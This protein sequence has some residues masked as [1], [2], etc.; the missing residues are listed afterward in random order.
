MSSKTIGLS[1]DLHRYLLSVTWEETDLLRRLRE[2]TEAMPMGRM[3]ISAEQGQFMRLLIELLQAKKTLE[4]G[5]FT[6]YSSLVVAQ[7]M[8]PEGRVVA[9]DVSEEWTSIGRRYWEEA[10]VA[11]KIDLRLGPA[12]ET[13]QK[14]VDSGEAGT[15]DFAFI[16]A[17]KSN[18][19]RYYEMALQLVRPRGL[20]GFDN[21]LWGGR[22]A[23][24]SVQDEDTQALRSLNETI[25][26]DERV[27]SSIVPIGDG[28][29]LALKR[30]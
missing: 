6:G 16:D 20:I 24:P 14:L 3:Q 27:T 18:Y 26:R 23:D 7:A 17:D 29:T 13:L 30:G 28:L 15:F 2:E 22:V 4:V 9:C 19:G 5:V 10:G 1:D 8:P 25:H 11:S 21:T 12:V